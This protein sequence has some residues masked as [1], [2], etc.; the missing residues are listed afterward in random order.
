MTSIRIHDPADG[1]ALPELPPLPIGALAA[2]AAE[3][4]QRAVDLP[5]PQYI[6]IYDI[7][8][9]SIQ[10]AREQA[11]SQAVTRWAHRFGSI[12][13]SQ[14]GEGKDGPETWYRTDFEYYGIAVTAY[15][16]VPAGPAGT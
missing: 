5:Q 1:P 13:T 4:L 2:G 6:A 7:Q 9:V 15:A 10:F 8:H 14:P 12:M 11:S 3:L 16:H